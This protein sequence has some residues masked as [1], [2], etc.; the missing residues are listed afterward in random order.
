MPFP[1]DIDSSD[2][3]LLVQ[4]LK[5]KLVFLQEVEELAPSMSTD[6]YQ[7]HGRNQPLIEAISRTLIGDCGEEKRPAEAKYSRLFK[8][9]ILLTQATQAAIEDPNFDHMKFDDTFPSEKTPYARYFESEMAYGEH[10]VN[11]QDGHWLCGSE[12]GEQRF[13]V[14]EKEFLGMAAKDAMPG[15]AVCLLYGHSV[16]F[17][18]R[19]LVLGD[20]GVRK[21]RMVGECFVHGLMDGE[22]LELGLAEENFMLC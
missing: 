14:T 9:D 1:P 22:G 13:C 19:P 4:K 20:G 6:P 15:D 17:V 12:N 16:P 21:Y 7:P 3:K 2:C 5:E 10:A 11:S 18:L 8:E